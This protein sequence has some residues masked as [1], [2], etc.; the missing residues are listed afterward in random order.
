VVVLKLEPVLSREIEKN[1]GEE[2]EKM[3]ISI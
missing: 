1:L 3:E 2:S